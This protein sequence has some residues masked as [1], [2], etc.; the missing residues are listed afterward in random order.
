MGFITKLAK[1]VVELLSP[2]MNSFSDEEQ[3]RNVLLVHRGV[4]VRELMEDI[5]DLVE[6]ANKKAEKMERV[7]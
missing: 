3:R 6:K 2:S 1:L 7:G 4:P 5:E